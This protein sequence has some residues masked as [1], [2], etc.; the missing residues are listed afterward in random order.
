M[1]LSKVTLSL[2]MI[3]CNIKNSVEV[4]KS[5]FSPIASATTTD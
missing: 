1:S 5:S 2:Y 4:I 3:A